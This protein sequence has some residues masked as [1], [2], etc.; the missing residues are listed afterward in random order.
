MGTKFRWTAGPP[1]ML[2]SRARFELVVELTALWQVSSCRLGENFAP[3]VNIKAQESN[4]C[5]GSHRLL[6]SAQD[7]AIYR[8]GNPSML[9]FCIP[10]TTTS[11]RYNLKKD[12]RWDSRRVRLLE[13]LWSESNNQRWCDDFRNIRRWIDNLSCCSKTWEQHASYLIKQLQFPRNTYQ[14]DQSKQLG[15]FLCSVCSICYWK[16][17]GKE[18]V[19]RFLAKRVSPKSDSSALGY[20]CILK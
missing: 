4:T 17:F 14:S 7:F 12:I 20:V 2:D 9:N 10:Q 8:V 18:A 11:A 5:D 19:I 16:Q 1:P 15:V 3:L 13:L 6:P